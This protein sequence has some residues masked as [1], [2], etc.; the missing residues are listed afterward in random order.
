MVLQGLRFLESL[1]TGEG[2]HP[3]PGLSAVYQD[4]PSSWGQ[5]LCLPE[6]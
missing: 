2:P 1:L 4:A 3:L 6:W 5:T